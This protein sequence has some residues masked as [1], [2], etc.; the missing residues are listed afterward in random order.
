MLSCDRSG[1]L[2]GGKPATSVGARYPE[3][4]FYCYFIELHHRRSI[5]VENS[6]CVDRYDRKTTPVA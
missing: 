6:S 1:M 3:R 4:D 5:G 2:M